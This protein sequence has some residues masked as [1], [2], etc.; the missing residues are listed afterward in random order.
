MCFPRLYAGEV[1]SLLS[2]VTLGS[3]Y[4]RTTQQGGKK[5]VSFF[6]QTAEV[7]ILAP[8]FTVRHRQFIFFSELPFLSL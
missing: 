1:L 2:E 4:T 7:W 5:G 3:F 6:L 8:A